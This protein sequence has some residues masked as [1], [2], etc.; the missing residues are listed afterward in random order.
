LV[1]PWVE[2]IAV[3]ASAE[4][5]AESIPIKLFSSVK[6]Y[7]DNSPLNFWQQV[8]LADHFHCCQLLAA[9]PAF[10]VP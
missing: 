1:A 10:E 6:L 5:I 7:I 4:K 2:E 9:W 3:L 8:V